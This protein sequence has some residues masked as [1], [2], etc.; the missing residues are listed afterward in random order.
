MIG[1]EAFFPV[2]WIT[3]VILTSYFTMLKQLIMFF[4]HM[5]YYKAGQ[6]LKHHTFIRYMESD[7]GE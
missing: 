7:N 4:E 5:Y 3:H 6:I 1:K 2:S